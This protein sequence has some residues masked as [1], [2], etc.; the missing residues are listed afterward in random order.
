MAHGYRPNWADVHGGVAQ[1]DGGVLTGDRPSGAAEVHLLPQ[2]VLREVY[3][4]TNYMGSQTYQIQEPDVPP[5]AYGG[6]GPR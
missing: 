2:L 4:T 3:D 5:A 6:S 1:A